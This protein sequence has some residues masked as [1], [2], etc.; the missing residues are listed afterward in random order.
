MAVKEREAAK[1]ECE[2]SIPNVNVVWKV[3]DEI[4]ESSPKFAIQSDVSKHT[5]VV[6]KCR[7]GDAGPISCAYGDIVTDARLIVQRKFYTLLTIT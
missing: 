3:K 2:F 1:F 7:P 4:V 5:L 6:S